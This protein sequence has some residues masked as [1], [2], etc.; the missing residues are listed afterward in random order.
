[1][2]ATAA[3]MNAAINSVVSDQMKMTTI[4]QKNKRYLK[5][6]TTTIKQVYNKKNRK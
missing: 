3:T 5:L 2:K 1:M 6:T 4:N